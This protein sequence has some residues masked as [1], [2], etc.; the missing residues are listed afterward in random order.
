MLSSGIVLLMYASSANV[1]CVTMRELIEGIR[2]ESTV[3]MYA[4]PAYHEY[5]ERRYL[6]AGL[7]SE[8]EA[9][10]SDGRCVARGGLRSRLL[11]DQC[12]TSLILAHVPVVFNS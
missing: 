10:N 7:A 9:A 11:Q 3:L 6:E 4:E 1:Y 2:A 12:L 8:S 5:I